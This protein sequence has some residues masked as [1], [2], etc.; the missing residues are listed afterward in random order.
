MPGHFERWHHQRE[1]F[2]LAMLALAKSRYGVGIASIGE[3]LESADTF[4]RNDLA[5]QE[6]FD[7]IFDRAVK[8]RPADGAGIGLR[9]EAAIRWVLVFLATRGTQRELPH[10]GVWPVVGD[11]DNDGVARAAIGAIG[12]R[13]FKAAIAGIEKFLAAVSAGGKIG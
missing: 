11:V 2:L 6:S 12:E 9:V 3:K 5:L 8:L 1:R 7:R 10:R 13:V 4:Q